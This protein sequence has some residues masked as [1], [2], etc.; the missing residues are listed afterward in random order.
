VEPAPP[1]EPPGSKTHPELG[2]LSTYS[3]VRHL[4]VTPT[5]LGLLPEQLSKSESKLPK[6]LSRIIRPTAQGRG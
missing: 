5:I 4:K 3:R 6:F 2:K 1:G